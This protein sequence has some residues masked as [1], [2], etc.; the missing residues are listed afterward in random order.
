MRIEPLSQAQTEELAKIIELADLADLKDALEEFV[1]VHG[2]DESNEH[3][4]GYEMTTI[5][6]PYRKAFA[7]GGAE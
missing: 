5:H 6:Y 3:D 7:K 2:Y 1:A 4:F